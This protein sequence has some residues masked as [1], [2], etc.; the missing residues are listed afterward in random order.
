MTLLPSRPFRATFHAYASSVLQLSAL[1]PVAPGH[2]VAK[3]KERR[4][5]AA[6][7]VRRRRSRVGR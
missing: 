2:F 1:A 4:L 3:K 5:G 6:L 7:G